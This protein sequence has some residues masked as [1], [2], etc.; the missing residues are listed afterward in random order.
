MHDNTDSAT[1]A[2]IRHVLAL[3]GISPSALAKL[4]GVSSTT[5]T[6]PLNNSQYKFNLSATTLEKIAAVSGISF[7]PFFDNKDFAEVS[8]ATLTDKTMY[9]EDKW[10]PNTDGPGTTVVIG[11][12]ALGIWQEVSLMYN[13]L[14]G[15]LFVRPTDYSVSD[16]FAL[17]VRD[18]HL[19]N[20]YS[21][22]ILLCVRRKAYKREIVSGDFVIL[23]RRKENGRLIELTARRVQKVKAGWQLS[24]T[25]RGNSDYHQ[26]TLPDFEGTDQ[27]SIIGV[28]LY[29]VKSVY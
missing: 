22:E 4:A 28:V 6:R 24:T 9:R 16:S 17:L 8:L 27:E 20:V 29:G 25:G 15:A 11:F 19:S 23:E 1:L 14:I 12:A 18:G 5:L 13:D 21:D 2:Y 26:I 10:G 7:A 3:M